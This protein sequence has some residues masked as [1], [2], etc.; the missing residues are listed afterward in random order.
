MRLLGCKIR[1]GRDVTPEIDNEKSG[2][3]HFAILV[4]MEKLRLDNS[5]VV[6]ID[7]SRLTKASE[8]RSEIPRLGSG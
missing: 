1:K 7:F 4:Y 6:E 2:N 8:A 5:A 3:R